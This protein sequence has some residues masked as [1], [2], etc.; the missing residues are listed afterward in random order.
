MSTTRT[1]SATTR[2]TQSKE[3]KMI[4]RMLEK[5]P[6]NQ[7]LADAIEYTEDDEYWNKIFLYASRG[8]LP[9][10]FY[11][12][13]NIICYKKS[14]TDIRKTMIPNDPYEAFLHLKEFLYNSAGIESDKDVR[15]K[16][17]EASFNKTNQ[18]KKRTNEVNKQHLYEYVKRCADDWNLSQEDYDSYKG[19]VFTLV[20]LTKKQ[21][22]SYDEDDEIVD[23]SM[24]DFDENRGVYVV[25]ES[26]LLEAENK[27][28]KRKQDAIWKCH[29]MYN[30]RSKKFESLGYFSTELQKLTNTQ[31]P[32]DVLCVT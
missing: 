5:P 4:E 25:S 12:R 18:I 27:L 26:V 22:I 1:R 3:E 31:I 9:T 32:E 14:K 7:T 24:I 20:T 16:K 17:D 10:G 28:S 21:Y 8:K 11:I 2:N 15:R 13:K 30:A 6:T 19:A 29:P 23:V